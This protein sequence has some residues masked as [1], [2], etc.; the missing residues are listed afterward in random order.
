MGASCGGPHA[1]MAESAMS[2]AALER[3]AR[4]GCGVPWHGCRPAPSL[5]SRGSSCYR[6]PR[7]PYPGLQDTCYSR[8]GPHFPAKAALLPWD[9]GRAHGPLPVF[10]GLPGCSPGN[11]HW[12]CHLA[13]PLLPPRPRPRKPCRPP[14]AHLWGQHLGGELSPPSLHAEPGFPPL[15]RN[16]LHTQLSA[17]AIC[18]LSMLCAPQGREPLRV[19]PPSSDSV[20]CLG[21]C[22]EAVG[23]VG[24][25]R[26]DGKEGSQQPCSEVWTPEVDDR[27]HP[28]G[29]G[30]LGPGAHGKCPGG[31]FS[32]GSRLLHQPCP[33]KKDRH[34][35]TPE[36]Q[37]L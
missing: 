13:S 15:F 22:G 20:D 23:G 28:R 10:P 11:R 7:S 35:G 24:N 16:T 8:V 18:G 21:R 26:S 19:P 14:A 3:G 32:P 27:Q 33:F 17:L 29:W 36:T 30:P 1:V 31:G 34:L 5:C 37:K 4:T 9:K 2:R 6:A 12:L 25:S